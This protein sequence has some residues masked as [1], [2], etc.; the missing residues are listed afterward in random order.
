MTVSRVQEPKTETTQSSTT[1]MTRSPQNVG[2]AG[3]S[4]LHKEPHH[5]DV[6]V[7]LIGTKNVNPY[8]TSSGLGGSSH[9]LH[10]QSSWFTEFPWLHYDPSVL[11]ILGYYCSVAHKLDLVDIA[12]NRDDGFCAIGYKNWKNAKQRFTAHAKAPSHLFAVE[13][14]SEFGKASQLILNLINK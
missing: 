3:Q 4:G 14:V 6:T 10:F 9:T 1:C 13:H 11:G 7:T 2:A 12:H 5:P 8:K